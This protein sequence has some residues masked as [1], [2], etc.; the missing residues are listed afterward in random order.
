[1]KVAVIGAGPAG[2]TTA[3]ILTKKGIETHVYEAGNK[4]GGLAKTIELWNQKVDLGPHRFFSMDA[5]VNN[6][7]LEVVNSDY[8]VVNRLTRILYENNF[9]YYPLK[10]L[11]TLLKL[12]ISKS[13]DCLFSYINYKVS[14]KTQDINDNF[15]LWIKDRF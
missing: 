8:R 9:F 12:G 3:Y 1:M 6:L 10:P 4:V 7:W 5:R 13:L 15:E 14:N 11:D 2:L